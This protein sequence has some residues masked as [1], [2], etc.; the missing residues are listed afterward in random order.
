MPGAS[1]WCFHIDKQDSFVSIATL[2]NRRGRPKK[3]R[4]RPARRLVPITDLSFVW[5]LESYI[6]TNRVKKNELLFP[7]SRQAADK[8]IKKVLKACEA[9]GHRFDTPVSAHTFRYSFAV[10]AILH[11]QTTETLQ[12]WLGHEDRQSTEIY[13]QV[14]SG[15]TADKMRQVKFR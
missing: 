15:D 9:S 1:P 8:R 3:G 11:F 10:N 2:K 12:K 6:T 14:L 5:E 4:T 7:I 13:T